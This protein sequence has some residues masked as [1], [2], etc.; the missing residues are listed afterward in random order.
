[1]DFYVLFYSPKNLLMK[2]NKIRRRQLPTCKL[3]TR[4]Y[5]LM[6]FFYLTQN[7]MA[8]HTDDVWCGKS[9]QK[10]S[11]SKEVS[12]LIIQSKFV[13]SSCNIPMNTLV[14]Y[15]NERMIPAYVVMGD[16]L[17]PAARDIYAR[18]N[19][20]DIRSLKSLSDEDIPTEIK[21]YAEKY[22]GKLVLLHR[23]KILSEY[24]LHKINFKKLDE[25]ARRYC[26]LSFHYEIMKVDNPYYK[27]L[28]EYAAYVPNYNEYVTGIVTDIHYGF[29]YH[30]AS[31]K[32]RDTIFKTDKESYYKL[33]SVFLSKEKQEANRL[34]IENELHLKNYDIHLVAEMYSSV[35]NH[36]YWIGTFS[37]YSDTVFLRQKAIS[38][39]EISFLVKHDTLLNNADTLL[40][41]QDY[42]VIPHSRG[43]CLSDTAFYFLRYSSELKQYVFSLF[44]L[45]NK[46]LVLDKDIPVPI[47]HYREASVPMIGYAGNNEVLLFFYSKNF[48][49]KEYTNVYRFKADEEK[50][51]L[52]LKKKE[53]ISFN[54]F[55]KTDDN[56]YVY[57]ACE[58]EKFKV[59]WYHSLLKKRHLLVNIKKEDW[60]DKSKSQISFNTD[61]QK[62]RLSESFFQNII[63][64]G[65]M[66][67]FYFFLSNNQVLRLVLK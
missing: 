63:G 18:Q 26:D 27:S 28:F 37:Y 50:F 43:Y 10:V 62:D 30:L 40:F 59:E 24:P 47:N 36:H 54:M 33:C 20:L 15:L 51:D 16:F 21:Q 60:E 4:G 41:K 29:Y 57:L 7:L 13:C 38:Q 8:M 11:Y 23:Q 2:S 34:I 58:K 25:I 45:K 66:P 3:K 1:M 56:A 35:S 42:M 55:Y 32:F 52:L 12:A 39:Y 22:N 14:E 17:T 5:R 44:K 31:N 19:N 46:Y 49:G 64:S 67:A 61:H 48:F 65:K 6:L 9:I 53:F